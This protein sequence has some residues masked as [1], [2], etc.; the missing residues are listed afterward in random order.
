[1]K[2][3]TESSTVMDDLMPGTE[4]VFRV[5]AGNQ[6]GSSPPSA[7]SE[8]VQTAPSL[9]GS[10]FS[11]EPFHDHYQL[12]NVIARSVGT[13]CI[14]NMYY[15][16]NIELCVTVYTYMHMYI[17]VVYIYPFMYMYIKCHVTGQDM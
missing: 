7:E 6:I 15:M 9:V 16:C 1:M 4:Y 11:L 10:D 2:R 5:I 17:I 14:D 8:P 13:T 12:I 3:I